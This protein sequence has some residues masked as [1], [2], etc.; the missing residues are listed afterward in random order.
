MGAK[1]NRQVSITKNIYV[2]ISNL[3]WSKTLV[4]KV[5]LKE[6]GYVLAAKIVIKDDDIRYVVTNDLSLTDFYALKNHNN[7][8]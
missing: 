7:H 3:D 5:W 1:E 8:R 2:S 4:Q 6:F